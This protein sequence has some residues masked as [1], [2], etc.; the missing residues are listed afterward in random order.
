[1]QV[2]GFF[3]FIIKKWQIGDLS[4]VDPPLATT[5]AHGLAG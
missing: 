4:L 1:M 2:T 5:E 3:G